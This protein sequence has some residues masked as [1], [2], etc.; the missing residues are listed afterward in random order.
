MATSSGDS[1]SFASS[2]GQLLTGSDW[3]DV[4]FEAFRPE[5]EAMFRS[6]GFQ[7]GWHVLDAGCGS[8]GF[9]PLIAEAV[10][11]TGRIVA[12][13][14]APDNIA[15][16]ER[17]TA[18]WNETPPIEGRVGSLLDLPYADDAFDALW[19]ANTTQYLTDD[20]LAI[21]LGEMRRVVRSG[22]IVAIKEYDGTVPCIVPAPPLLLVHMCEACVV[23]R[24]EGA[25][26]GVRAPALAEW[27]RSV[28]MQEVRQHRVLAERSA[29]LGKFE[30]QFYRDWLGL[31]A[32]IAPSLD[33]PAADRAMWQQ[34]AD[35]AG[36][37]RLLD[38]PDLYCCEGH[39]MAIGTVP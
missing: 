20:Q 11:P 26:N 10:G 31:C 1:H 29:P 3:L 38:D 23:Q 32:T 7:P 4:H 37:D 17:R 15:I 22:G 8:G 30:R 39:I 6:V 12:F 2:T 21:A 18:E 28:G 5:Y 36:M 25:T 19:C 33:M 9:L 34:L 16:V 13:D 27:L 35:P 14:L 24:Y